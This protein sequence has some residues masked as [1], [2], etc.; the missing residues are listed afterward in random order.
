MRVLVACDAYIFVLPDG[1]HWTDTIYGYEFWERYLTVF[2]EVKIVARTKHVSKKNEKW[3]SVEGNGISFSEVPFYRGPFQLGK[4]YFSIQAAL[5]KVDAECDVA[6]LRMPSQTALMTWRHIRKQMPIGGEI[7][8]DPVDDYEGAT[9]P[10]MKAINWIIVKNLEKF[11]KKANG[12]SYVTTDAIQKHFPSNAR[13]YGSTETHF[14]TY[15]STITLL[16][17]AFTG[18]RKYVNGQKV[19][20]ALSSVAMNSE[21]K[22][23][24]VLIQIV[25]KCRDRGFDVDAV[26]IGDGDLKT[27]FEKYADSIGVRNHIHFTGLLPSSDAVREELLKS[28]IYV[29]PTQGEGLPRG[30]LEA[31]AIGL[32]VLSTPVG[33]IPEVLENACLFDPKDVDGFTNKICHL[34]KHADEMNRLSEMNYKVALNYKNSILQSKRDD[35]YKKLCALVKRT[36]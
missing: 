33:G 5:R 17:E 7:V 13:L 34:I 36:E 28:D 2:D 4:K 30:V 25:K 10:L 3:I 19:T 15:Y 23:E 31:M 16:D 20:L 9:S 24:R 8:Y 11:C 26:I 14:E 21:R 22:G 18:P 27:E 35:F 32:P 1:S 29:F 6:I 12:V